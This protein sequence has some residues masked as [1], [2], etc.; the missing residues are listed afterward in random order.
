MIGNNFFNNRS[1]DASSLQSKIKKRYGDKFI[2]NVAENWDIVDWKLGPHFAE[3]TV[4][5]YVISEKITNRAFRVNLFNK[6]S[7][8]V[9]VSMLKDPKEGYKTNIIFSTDNYTVFNND[10]TDK[11]Y[12]YYGSK[13]LEKALKL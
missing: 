3:E 1:S 2:G 13:K 10:A 9:G 11:N 7:K 5:R 6:L 8:Y 4:I 12:L